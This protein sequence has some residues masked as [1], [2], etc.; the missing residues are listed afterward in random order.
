MGN[1]K[2]IEKI[3]RSIDSQH[4]AILATLKKYISFKSINLEQLFEGEKS[5]IKECQ[6]W[7]EQQISSLRYF[8]TVELYELQKNAPNVAAIKKGSG[9]GKSLLLNAHSDVVRVS[10]EQKK[11]WQ[12]LS[13]WD[14]GVKDGKAWGRGASDMKGGG[15]ALLYAVK[16]IRDL[17]VRLKGDL[18][19]S[20]CEGEESGRAVEGIWSLLDRGFTADCAIMAEPTH[21]KIYHRTRGEIYFDI[22]ISGRS[23]HICNR[24]LTIWPQKSAAEQVGV[25]AID[26]MVTMLERLRDLERDWGLTYYDDEIGPGTT[27]L[28]VSMI[29]AGESFSAQ[30]GEC[31]ISLASMFDPKATVEEIRDQIINAID[32]VADSDHWLRDHR[33]T[34]SHPFPPKVPIN[35][36][37]SSPFV[38]TVGRSYADITSKEPCYASGPF[39][40]DANYLY[41]KGIPSLY[42]GPG[43]IG[44]AHGTNEYIDVTEVFDA[45]KIYAAMILN[46]CL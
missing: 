13:P 32:S 18:V 46:W 35:I 24:N 17:D 23:A 34:Y 11:G 28:A 45:A 31:R 27:T 3:H 22:D 38:Q 21:F 20:Y 33:P 29:R 39:V 19:L 37:R 4:D 9:G 30:A 2:L 43:E 16:A 14:G 26:K 10:E 12:V 5:E 42:F 8:D 25:N 15:T 36:P 1:E 40:G 6:Q 44:V 41:E 7:L